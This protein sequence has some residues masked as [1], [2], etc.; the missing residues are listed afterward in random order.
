MGGVRIGADTNV[1]EGD[2]ILLGDYRGHSLEVDLVHDAVA[3]RDYIDIVEGL[4]APVDE[5]EAVGIAPVLDG[6]VALEGVGVAAGVFHRQRVIDDQLRRHHRVDAGWVAALSGD[7]VAQAGQVH[8]RG[9]AEDVVADHAH[10][11]PGKIPLAPALDDLQQGRFE[12]LGIA[13]AQQLLG[14]HPRDIGQPLPGARAQRLDR[15]AGIVVVQTGA[16]QWLALAGI[17]VAIHRSS[18]GT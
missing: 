9:L 16:G 6:A 1:G 12:L 4:L 13:A 10:R 2:A 17:G 15:R 14:Q 3:G 18:M 11:I 8:Q 7:G 5:M